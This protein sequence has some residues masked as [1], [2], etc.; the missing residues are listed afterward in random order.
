M[1]I[2]RSG[3]ISF[4]RFVEFVSLYNP[5]SAKINECGEE[6]QNIDEMYLVLDEYEAMKGVLLVPNIS[7]GFGTFC[8][9]GETLSHPYSV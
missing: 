3:L 4:S 6:I 8:R 9:F 2:P 5:L 1:F 7:L